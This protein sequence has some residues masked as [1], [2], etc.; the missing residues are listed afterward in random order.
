[1]SEKS[2]NFAGGIEKFSLPFGGGVMT[3][4]KI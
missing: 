3:A 4:S 2:S 1:M